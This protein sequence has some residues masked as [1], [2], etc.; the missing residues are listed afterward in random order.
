[1]YS[2]L[3]RFLDGERAAPLPTGGP[4]DD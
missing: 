2:V 4:V 3:Q 1:V